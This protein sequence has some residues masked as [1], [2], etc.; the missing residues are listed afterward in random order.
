MKVMTYDE[1]RSWCRG[2]EVELTSDGDLRYPG[3]S[4]HKFFVLAPE[5]F[6]RIMALTGTI[7][8]FRGEAVFSGGLIWLRRWDIGTSRLARVGWRV[9]EDVRR[10]HGDSRSLE[11]APAQLFRDD[12]IS[13][14]HAFLMLIICFGWVAEFVPAASRDFFIHF[15]DNRQL[16]FTAG[17]AALLEELR[18]ALSEWNPTRQ[19]PMVKRL[20]ELQRARRRNRSAT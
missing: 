19:D 15:K 9:I 4:E 11:V 18:V 8:S 5:E 3:Q 20:T 7:V 14:L 1:A 16:C 2:A 17:S 13:E 6:R 12:E 10:A